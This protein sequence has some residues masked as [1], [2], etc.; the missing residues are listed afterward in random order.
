MPVQRRY[1]VFSLPPPRHVATA[2]GRRYAR[3]SPPNLSVSGWL[4]SSTWVPE[5]CSFELAD[6]DQSVPWPENSFDVVSPLSGSLSLSYAGA[7]GLI[8]GILPS[9]IHVRDINVGITNYNLLVEGLV[10]CLRPGGV[11]RLS[12][13]VCLSLTF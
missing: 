10:G 3:R 12:F 6:V 5:N 4:S 11:S 8:T 7:K 13:A 1:V 9:K 2:R